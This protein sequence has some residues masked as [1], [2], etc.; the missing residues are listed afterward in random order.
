MLCNEAELDAGRTE[1]R[2]SS[3]EGALLAAAQNAGLDYRELRARYPRVIRAAASRQ[4]QL[5]GHRSTPT[6]QALRLVAVKG[7]PEEVLARA[8]AL[9]RRRRRPR[10]S[11]PNP[12]PIARRRELARSPGAGLRVL[13]LA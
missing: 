1:L 9:A 7:A 2:G 11:T 3:T 13:G 8:D 5:D 12:T 10:R 6:A 4:R